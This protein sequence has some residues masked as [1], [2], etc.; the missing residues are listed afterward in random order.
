MKTEIKIFLVLLL[1]VVAAGLGWLCQALPGRPISVSLEI[2]A[3]NVKHKDARVF[4]QASAG[5]NGVSHGEVRLDFLPARA[6][7]PETGEKS[8][9]CIQGYTNTHGVF[10]TNW[11]PF[12]PG[13]YIVTASVKK[14]GFVEGHSIGRV[15][16]SERQVAPN[17][18]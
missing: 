7:D 13:E 1:V 16:V 6:N 2:S 12:A 5:R 17:V 14:A 8:K 4:L 11:T 3:D 15:H 10:I 9:C 18:R